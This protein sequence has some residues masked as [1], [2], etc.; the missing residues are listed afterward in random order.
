MRSQ[1]TDVWNLLTVR[2][3]R[4]GILIRTESRGTCLART[5]DDAIHSGPRVHRGKAYVKG[6]EILTFQR[7]KKD[8]KVNARKR[9]RTTAGMPK[10]RRGGSQGEA[11][12]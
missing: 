11:Q 3:F 5:A 12:N 7:G 1:K 2:T 10:L 4:K 8:R 9:Y 6:N